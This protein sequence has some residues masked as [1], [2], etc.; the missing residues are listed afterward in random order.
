LAGLAGGT[1]PADAAAVSRLSAATAVEL[2]DVVASTP[3]PAV[4]A[5]GPGVMV[6]FPRGSTR[7]FPGMDA[8]D[9]AEGGDGAEGGDE[10][11]EGG[12]DARE[13]RG[14][15]TGTGSG[16]VGEAEELEEEDG[17]GGFIAGANESATVDG[18]T[19]LLLVLLSACI[20]VLSLPAPAP[21][22]PPPTTTAAAVA[23]AAL[24]VCPALLRKVVTPELTLRK[25]PRMGD[26]A[27]GVASDGAAGATTLLRL[28]PTAPLLLLLLS[29]PLVPGAKPMV[30]DGFG[31][32]VGL[33][34]VDLL[35]DA[36]S[37]TAAAAAAQTGVPLPSALDI[38]V[39]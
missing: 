19:L 30:F 8:D 11:E 17:E 32:G 38:L 29:A 7:S 39:P 16:R 22:A 15:G 25:M 1:I 13:G 5:T 20:A 31:G 33:G 4:D 37:P 21:P 36:A 10:A 2:G 26:T 28:E 24:M 12:T 9:E 34:L 3:A 18:S 6:M 14:G 35:L 27:A 23:V